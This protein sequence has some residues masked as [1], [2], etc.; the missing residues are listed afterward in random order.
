MIKKIITYYKIDS[1][2]FLAIL[3]LS[4]GWLIYLHW[5]GQIF[6]LPG[7]P[8]GTIY[9]FWQG[10]NIALSLAPPA[11]ATLALEGWVLTTFFSPVTAY[12]ILIVGGFGLAFLGAYALGLYLTQNRFIA[13]F[14]GF[15]WML[16]PAH[17][18]QSFQ[19]LGLASVGWFPI[20]IL[21]LL[22]LAR[23]N[24]PPILAVLIG[25]LW[26]WSSLE[27]F[28]NGYFILITF[29]ILALVFTLYK[30]IITKKIFISLKA[31]GAGVIILLVA[32]GIILFSFLLPGP[33]GEKPPFHQYEELAI[34]SAQTKSYFLPSPLHL[35]WGE[36]IRQRNKETLQK[37]N[38]FEQSLFLGYTTIALSIFAL[39]S[40]FYLKR[41][42]AL[43][44]SGL[45]LA[46]VSF[47]FSFAP[48]IEFWGFKFYT[49]AHYL[50]QWL[51]FF[52]V[53][54]RF[55]IIVFLAVLVLA[56]L[57]LEN[58]GRL[59][60]KGKKIIPI[61]AG[62]FIIF[63]FLPFFPTFSTL[64]L[65]EKS[66]VLFTL[67]SGPKLEKVAV[68]PL[69]KNNETRHYQYLYEKT[70]HQYPLFNEEPFLQNDDRFRQELYDPNSLLVRQQMLSFGVKYFLI[71]K[72]VYQ[73]GR[74]PKSLALFYD[75]SYNLYP[76]EF[77]EGKIPPI[78]EGEKIR[79]I[80]EDGERIL[81][82]LFP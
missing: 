74:L 36:K 54:A 59:L 76:L 42:R 27:S 44:L 53:Y 55:G 8:W 9:A 11:Q 18:V 34:Y 60:P 48:E 13:L 52:R 50:Y 40:A 56:I 39:V 41:R 29:F 14:A 72:S 2:I 38:F 82:E 28:Y 12:N 49:P 31:V 78:S 23:T 61:L 20:L 70:F 33:R 25:F 32:G 16:A 15:A 73:E 26:T 7:D 77:N 62:V 35:L 22:K 4:I 58:I 30:W 67:R 1:L 10:K 24:Y 37:S 75:P 51:P 5:Q 80:A 21:L 3:F 66:P 71:Y 65:A 57:G 63:E 68:Y 46:L 6:G 47:F 17:L 43:A 45:V 79:K 19:H 81:Y 64:S 69:V